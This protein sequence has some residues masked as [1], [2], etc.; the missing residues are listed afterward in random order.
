M[1]VF[2][3]EKD[4]AGIV[5]VIMD[6]AGPVNAMNAEYLEAMEQTLL[7]LEQ[8]SRLRG[9][10]LASGK[11]TFFAGGDIK[12]MMNIR[13]EEYASFYERL[14]TTKAQLRRLELLPVPIVAAI[15]G[16]ALGGGFEICLVCNHR[17]VLDVPKAV[18]G[19]PEITLGLLPGGGG[20]VRL[21]R[22]LGLQKALPLLLEG[23]PHLPQQALKLGLVDQCVDKAEDLIPQA[24]A[25]ILSNHAFAQQPWQQDGYSV[26]GGDATTPA[27]A[28]FLALC[29]QQARAATRGLL[30]A[31]ECLIDLAG[32]STKLPLHAALELEGKVAAELTLSAQAKNIMTTKFYQMNLVRRA[33]QQLGDTARAQTKRI[34]IVGLIG[35]NS[36]AAQALAVAAWAKGI[37]VACGSVDEKTRLLETAAHHA[38]A[39]PESAL[40]DM[41]E[42]VESE[43]QAKQ[44][45][46]C[47]LIF[48]FSVDSDSAQRSQHH[49]LAGHGVY[50]C[51][52]GARV[53]SEDTGFRVLRASL[54]MAGSS[55]TLVELVLMQD[56]T[57]TRLSML[58]AF[59]HRIGVITIVTKGYDR[60]FVAGVIAAY[61]DE[62][63]RLLQEN[64]AADVIERQAWRLG[65]AVADP[66]LASGNAQ[67]L[68]SSQIEDDIRDRL[69]FRQVIESVRYLEQGRLESVADV[70][71]ATVL[72]AGAPSWTG[73]YLQ[74]INTYDIHAFAARAAELMQCYGDRF[75][76]PRLFLHKLETRTS[77]L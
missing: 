69:L 68:S 67:S 39:V 51:V 71:V 76:L 46:A 1:N 2:R 65:M 16:A 45:S 66:V 31:P 22:L 20:T 8:E 54:H 6:M 62:R 3:Y 12:D 29:M 74:V 56:D 24:K 25:W 43:E 52:N 53:V 63:Q 28:E 11:K 72:A 55:I 13:P 30:P 32:R 47:D 75:A 4:D 58:M 73:G 61:D 37:H 57:R 36:A 10:V 35:E 9:V 7:R 34:G 44:K 59:L 5:T 17:I 60:G 33:M 15:N 48:D 77:F 19:L 21:V 41:I 70:N 26:P 40:S 18:V 42:V 50:V 38:Q 27:V 64:I 14:L 23:K 49:I